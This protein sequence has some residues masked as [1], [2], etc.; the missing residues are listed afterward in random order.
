MSAEMRDYQS[1]IK[2]QVELR[3]EKCKK[4][5]RRSHRFFAFLSV[6]LSH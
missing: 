2:L 5:V 1:R 6:L 4:I 3:V